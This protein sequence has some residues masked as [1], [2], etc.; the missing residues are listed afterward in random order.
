MPAGRATKVP[1]I[2]WWTLIAAV[3]GGLAGLLL[4]ARRGPRQ[5]RGNVAVA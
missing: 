2:V 5:A 4:G 3:A 1:G